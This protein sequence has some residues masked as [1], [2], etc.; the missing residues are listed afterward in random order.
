MRNQCLDRFHVPN[1]EHLLNTTEQGHTLYKQ[2]VF[3]LFNET[4]KNAILTCIERERNGEEQNRDLL[5]DSIAV[6]VEFDNFLQNQH[7]E[8][9]IYKNDFHKYLITETKQYYK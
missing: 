5:R 6:F 4:A 3:E 1:N 8:L 7:T 9:A 2:T